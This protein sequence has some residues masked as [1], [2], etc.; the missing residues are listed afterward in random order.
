MSGQAR[1]W[2][3]WG[4]ADIVQQTSSKA[5]IRSPSRADVSF[6]SEDA[7]HPLMRPLA[8]VAI[9]QCGERASR[10][11]GVLYEAHLQLPSVLPR[12]RISEVINRSLPAYS[13]F[14]CQISLAPFPNR[15]QGWTP[16]G[17]LCSGARSSSARGQAGLAAWQ[18]C[19]CVPE[20]FHKAWEKA[21]IKCNKSPCLRPVQISDVGNVLDTIEIDGEISRWTAW[22]S[23]L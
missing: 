13:H 6:Q 21:M 4:L 2:G 1:R 23:L 3:P 18:P 5:N 20:H 15:P 22:Q 19:T 16:T 8:V 10:D 12:S 9:R 17:G 11:G 7:P 14:Q